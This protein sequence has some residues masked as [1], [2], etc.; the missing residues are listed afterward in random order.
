M[1]F[2]HPLFVILCTLL[3]FCINVVSEEIQSNPVSVPPSNNMLSKSVVDDVIDAIETVELNGQA[4]VVDKI[5]SAEGYLL[6]EIDEEVL[7]A[8]DEVS[9]LLKE[10]NQIASSLNDL[11]SFVNMEESA[12]YTASASNLNL[13]NTSNIS[14]TETMSATY[15]TKN[16]NGDPD[17]LAK[18]L[19]NHYSLGL[20]KQAL[21]GLKGGLLRLKENTIKQLR[22]ELASVVK[23]LDGTS[24]HVHVAHERIMKHEAVLKKLHLEAEEATVDEE[25]RALLR[26]GGVVD[27][28]TGRIH[29]G[30]ETSEEKEF[31]QNG[32][33]KH[34]KVDD[35]V[36][37]QNQQNIEQKEKRHHLLEWISRHPF[38]SKLQQLQRQVMEDGRKV[39]NVEVRMAD[40]AVMNVNIRMLIDVCML[41]MF[42]CLGGV[43][44]SLVDMPPLVGYLCGGLVVGPSGLHLVQ[45][46]VEVHTL[47][48]FGSIFMLFMCGFRFPM[49]FSNSNAFKSRSFSSLHFIKQIFFMEGGGCT[50][51]S[52]N[53]SKNKVPTLSS[54]GGRRDNLSRLENGGTGD[55]DKAGGSEAFPGIRI[56][57]L[58][59]FLTFILITFAGYTTTSQASAMNLNEALCYGGAMSISSTEALRMILIKM[60]KRK[61]QFGVQLLQVAAVQDLAI[62]LMLALPITLLGGAMAFVNTSFSLVVFALCAVVFNFAVAPAALRFVWEVAGQYGE[63]GTQVFLLGMVSWCLGLALATDVLGLSLEFGAFVSGIFFSGAGAFEGKSAAKLEPLAQFFGALFFT[64]VGMILNPAWAL[65]H[66]QDILV[67]LLHVSMCKIA[68]TSLVLIWNGWST[69]KALVAGLCMAQVGD[70]TLIYVSNAFRLGLLHRELYLNILAATAFMLVGVPL[71][72]DFFVGKDRRV[73]DL[74]LMKSDIELSKPRSPHQVK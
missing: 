22:E 51:Q 14:E 2:S 36:K 71:L 69:K 74:N 33:S 13:N 6:E 49:A 34:L 32:L 31:L 21:D 11:D 24:E 37:K 47:T 59:L 52:K 54:P 39:H 19:N 48:Q 30:G 29:M 66:M 67:I 26:A 57:S 41:F 53:R 17:T 28:A 25:L 56:G 61:K 72:V 62:G 15:A 42:A 35:K 4:T 5:A 10:T 50:D 65:T 38:D 1:N 18:H 70:F 68:I 27:Y 9:K 40:P 63:R 73:S 16:L 64:S 20:D 58:V 45:D 43:L 46:I 55:G 44:T 3:L 8:G 12:L 7:E 60:K 23:G